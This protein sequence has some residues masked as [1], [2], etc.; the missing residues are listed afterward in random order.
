MKE[1]TIDLATFEE[2]K[3]TA[4]ADFVHELVGTFLVE[5]PTMLASLRSAYDASDAD[6][7]RRGAHSLKSNS[8]T[9]GATTLAALAKQLELGGLAQ[10]RA[11][12]KVSLDAVD[13]E[14]AR[15]AARLTELCRG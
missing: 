1:P 8:N 6:R 13:A 10:V 14:Y 12:G 2:L 15:V 7:F 4:G 3:A 5:A 9:F 11:L